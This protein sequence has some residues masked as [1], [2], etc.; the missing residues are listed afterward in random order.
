[1]AAAI[2]GGALA[3]VLSMGLLIHLF[4]GPKPTIEAV[5]PAVGEPGSTVTLRGD[6]FADGA[7]GNVVRF[8]GR[9]IGGEE[10]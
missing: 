4:F 6:R 5:Q 2:G 9:L 3:L 10:R 8:G 7:A 1:M